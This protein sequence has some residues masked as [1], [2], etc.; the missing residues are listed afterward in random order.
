MCG[1]SCFKWFCPR[2]NA[3]E[4]RIMESVQEQRCVLLCFQGFHLSGCG[5]DCDVDHLRHKPAS[6]AVYL[7]WRC[8]HVHRAHIPL[9]STQDSGEFCAESTTNFDMK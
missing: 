3:N 5:P 9:V 4:L 1:L 8:V 2:L 6:R 7:I